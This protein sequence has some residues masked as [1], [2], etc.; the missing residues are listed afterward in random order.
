[1]IDRTHFTIVFEGD[2][3]KLKGNPLKMETALRK[4]VASGAASYDLVMPSITFQ[5]HAGAG[6]HRLSV[7]CFHLQWIALELGDIALKDDREMSSVDHMP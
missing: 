6:R 2:I 4:P 3:T 5:K 7:G 1:M